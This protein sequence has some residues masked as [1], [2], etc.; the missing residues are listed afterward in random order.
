[1]SYL[2]SVNIA[3]LVATII[4][5]CWLFWIFRSR[6]QKFR[7]GILLFPF[8]VYLSCIPVTVAHLL[9]VRGN[10]GE[11]LF[12]PI[13]AKV[14]FETTIVLFLVS[15]AV[16]R[17]VSDPL[18]IKRIIFSTSG[19]MALMF[20]IRFDGHLLTL[21]RLLQK[22]PMVSLEGRLNYESDVRVPIDVSRMKSIIT[23]EIRLDS[24]EQPEISVA[25]GVDLDRLNSF[26]RDYEKE[27][28]R[29]ENHHRNL[30]RRSLLA[31]HYG[32]EQQFRMSAGFGR[33]RTLNMGY[34]NWRLDVP[35]VPSLPLRKSEDTESVG[36]ATAISAPE[37]AFQPWHHS[38]LISFVTPQSVGIVG[39]GDKSSDLSKTVGFQEH[40]VRKYPETSIPTETGVR[41]LRID[42]MLLVS[43]LKHR[44]P[45]V[46]VS[47]NL[48]NMKELASVPTRQPNRFETDALEQLMS[49]ED[50]V[51][52]AEDSQ[53]R[54]VGSI[55]AA[56]QCLECHQVPR[57]TLLGAFS[58]RLSPISSKD[59]EGL[60]PI[61][62][63]AKPQP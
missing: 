6:S 56:F 24:P 34:G 21:S 63:S 16:D 52:K 33:E 18:K 26:E 47:E 54:M 38:N 28:D 61:T 53:I 41:S 9:L 8:L 45:A 62:L 25:E 37:S 14:A 49:G 12:G 43:I 11:G 23:G 3:V 22:H 58:Y 5:T 10:Q 48:P 46:Y 19:I 15:L 40:A 13:L 7:R 51:I 59:A 60:E 17:L 30:S 29:R 1:M 39:W 50:L 44:P 32:I 2:I 55:R 57:G 42:S 31:A 35:D 27:A 20:I 4:P 36:Y